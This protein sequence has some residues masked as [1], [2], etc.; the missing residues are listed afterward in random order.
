MRQTLH[1]F[2]KDV[3]Y[4]RYEI[5]LIAL[6]ALVFAG[7]HA[8]PARGLSDSWWAEMGLVAAAAFLVGRLVLAEAIPG[9][10]QFWITRPYRWQSLLGAKLLFIVTF[11]NLPVFLA[12][13]FI[14]IIDGFPL[15]A[16]V[17]GLLW[18]QVLLFV[19]VALPFATLAT[20]NSGMAPFIFSQLI[21]LAAVYGVWQMLPRATPQLGGVEWL[22]DSMAVIFLAAICGAVLWVQYKSRRTLASRSLAIGAVAIAAL[23]FVAMPWPLA[24][25]VETKLS[26]Q[27]EM[28]SSIQLALGQQPGEQSWPARMKPKVAL[29]LPISMQGIPDGAE[30][31][32]DALSISLQGVEGGVTT[33]G[34][35][36]CFELKRETMSKSAVIV[37]AVCLVDPAFFQRQHGHP[38]TLRAAL[39]F[40]LFGNARSQTI[41][42]SDEPANVLDGLQCYTDTVKAEWDI[43]CRSAFRWPARL[44]YAKLGD[45][46]AKSFTQ[47]VSYSPFP[48]GLNIDP[49]ETRW[50][51]AYAAGPPPTKRVRDVTI[52]VE[53]PLAHLRR[54]FEAHDVGLDKLVYPSVVYQFIEAIHSH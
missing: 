6:I 24:L 38:V 41:P 54:D 44:I 16:S 42:L 20:L 40:T 34:T 53:E 18:S 50:A 29:H 14:L 15:A 22:P 37:S 30:V 36:D 33:A 28:G 17:P 21:V 32:T 23:L 10:R 3:R 7:V 2:K 51:S 13:L 45:T 8:R 5:A 9:D 35:S 43:Y 47:I 46:N 4:L 52:V 25:A 49:V 31:Q 1:I 11:V 26:K 12:H 19:I 39:Y 27:P 48:A